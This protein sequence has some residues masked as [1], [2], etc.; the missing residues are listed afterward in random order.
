MDEN[1][2]TVVHADDEVTVSVS[3]CSFLPGRCCKLSP[4]SLQYVSFLIPRH[5]NEHVCPGI[6]HTKEI[7]TFRDRWGMLFP[8]NDCIKKQKHYFCFLKSC[9]YIAR[10]VGTYSTPKDEAT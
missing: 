6:S 9:C 3:L 2:V 1:N 4:S 10:N 5:E 7:G 8:V